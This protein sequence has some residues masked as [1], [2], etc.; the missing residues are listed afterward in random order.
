MRRLPGLVVDSARST[1]LDRAWTS[2]DPRPACRV[3]GAGRWVDEYA[4]VDSLIAWLR[5]A[6]W[7]DNTVF[8]ADGPDGTVYGLHHDGLTCVLEGH[9]DGGDDSDTTYVPSDTLEVSA[10]CAA[11][12]PGDTT[13]PR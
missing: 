1:S 10:T 3:Q 12:L 11:T 7:R 4:S 8:Q 6:G 13:L 5:A 9:W 2:A